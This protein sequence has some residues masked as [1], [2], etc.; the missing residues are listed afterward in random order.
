MLLNAMGSQVNWK[1]NDILY[2][3]SDRQCTL[4]TSNPYQGFLVLLN[5][6]KAYTNI[7]F[8]SM[9]CEEEKQQNIEM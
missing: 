1:C 8:V 5:S 3:I 7:L 2:I 9:C 6:A 4:T